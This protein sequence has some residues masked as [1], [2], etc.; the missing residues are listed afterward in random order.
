MNY[1]AV[2]LTPTSPREKIMSSKRGSTTS[3][4]STTT[5]RS[6]D[7]NDN[8]SNDDSSNSNNNK[9]RFPPSGGQK[10]DGRG[11][12]RLF[13]QQQQHTQ[14]APWHVSKRAKFNGGQ[15]SNTTSI[16]TN[17][18]A[19]FDKDKNNN[20]NNKKKNNDNDKQDGTTTKQ[21]FCP[22]DLG[23]VFPKLDQSDPSHA[24]RIQQRRK[25]IQ[26]GKNTLGYAEYLR[27][28]PK[29]KRRSRS[30]KTPSTPDHTLDIPAK[31]WQGIVK[32]W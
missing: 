2:L 26:M 12:R 14:G 13:N 24:R 6:G 7:S 23:T 4:N 19:V 15:S 18:D 9:N 28:V 25:Q 5:N 22:M 32:S 30:M 8:K 21:V 11:N 16:S 20:I 10:R 17:D 29:D 1:S 27:R 3:T 31:R